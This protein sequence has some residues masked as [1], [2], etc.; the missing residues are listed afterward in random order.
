M[1]SR[2]LIEQAKQARDW[3]FFS[4]V[5]NPE[6]GVKGLLQ[7][8][9]QLGKL[10]RDFDPTPLI[11][12]AQHPHEGVRCAATKSLARLENPDLLPFLSERL[13]CETATIVRRELVSAIGRLKTPAAIPTL[14]GALQDPDA[15]V[16][17]QAVRGL[18]IFRDQPQVQNVLQTLLDHPNELVRDALNSVL[19]PQRRSSPQRPHWHSPDGLKNLMVRGDALQVLCGIP[20]ESIHLTFTSPPYY[21]ARDYMLYPSYEAYL[22]F[23]TAVFREVHRVTKEGRF[24]VLNTSPVLVP[25]MSRQHSSKRYAIPFD[26]HPRIVQ[27]GFEF[28]DDIIWVKPAPSAKNRNGGFYQHRKPLGYKANSV[29]EYVMVYR[30][31]ASKLIDWNMRQYPESI[32]EAS[33]V[34]GTYEPTNLW[35][36]APSADPV[37]PAVFPVELALQVIQLYSYKGDLILDPFAG[38]G[39]VGYAA[40]LLERYFFLIEKEPTYFEYAQQVLAEGSLF[41]AECRPRFLKYDEFLALKSEGCET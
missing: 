31:A 8:L 32:I 37:H 11:H 7:T 14:L 18:L 3:T 15:K 17:L 36:I 16:V 28:I 27:L 25:R 6:Q 19:Q 4:R 21:N 1:A 34:H 30:K 40:L 2:L 39:T 29:V 26:I 35:A 13:E 38:R 24:F 23:L 9:E 12:L 5:L 33:R 10:P 22:D 41:Q 20:D